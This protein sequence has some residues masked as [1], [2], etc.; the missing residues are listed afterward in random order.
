[1]IT[2]TGSNKSKDTVSNN[3][4][5]NI[6]VSKDLL[7]NNNKPIEKINKDGSRTLTFKNGD[8]HKIGRDGKILIVP[9]AKKREDEFKDIEIDGNIIYFDRR[10]NIWKI[11]KK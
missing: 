11:K 3:V 5:N 9:N 8:V 7:Y 1:M 4:R 6:I 10:D 2:C